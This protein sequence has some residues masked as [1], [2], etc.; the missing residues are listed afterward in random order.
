MAEQIKFIQLA[1]RAHTIL[2]SLGARAAAGFLR[3][4]NVCLEDA[5]VLLGMPVRKFN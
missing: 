5:L 4:R 2:R 1:T 3:N